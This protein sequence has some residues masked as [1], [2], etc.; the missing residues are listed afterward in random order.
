MEKINSQAKNEVN[1]LLR[2]LVVDPISRDT[3][4]KLSSVSDKLSEIDG[5]SKSLKGLK[6][7][8]I[9]AKDKTIAKIDELPDSDRID[10]LEKNYLKKFKP[11]IDSIYED[12]QQEKQDVGLIER[13]LDELK[14][15]CV[16]GREEIANTEERQTELFETK[17]SSVLDKLSEIDGVSESL[18][19]IKG[20]IIDAKDKTVAKINEL[21][22]YSDRI[23]SMEKNYLKKFKPQIDSIYEDIQQ[24]KQDVGLI[25]RKLDELKSKCVSGREEIANTE[26]RQTELLKKINT[27]IEDGVDTLISISDKIDEKC[28][29]LSNE[30][31]KLGKQTKVLLVFIIILTLFNVLALIVPLLSKYIH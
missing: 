31:F 4:E 6:G 5:V 30:N 2:E 23:D 12:I 9:D 29:R 22:D 16:S 17:L 13:K 8:I 28:L 18:T 26:E 24:E 3:G 14:S 7:L 10:S 1:E 27:K 21:P 25:E 11:Q 19:G 15:E 20:L